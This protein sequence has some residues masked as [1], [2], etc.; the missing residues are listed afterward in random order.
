MREEFVRFK[1][2]DRAQWGRLRD[3]QLEVLSA[4]PWS[5]DAKPS[6]EIVVAS[7]VEWLAP[8]EPSK[9]VCVGLNYR[10]HAA[11]MGEALPE[12]PKLFLKPST[13]LLDPGKSILLPRGS[14]RV[15]YEAELAFVVGTKVGPGLDD[16][17]ALFGFTCANDVTARDLQKKDGQWTRAKGFDTFCP[18]GP[19]LVRG[20]DTADL[21]VECWVNGERKQSSRS[22]QLIFRPEQILN[23]VAEV[24]TLLPGDVI[25]TGTP[26]GIG[27]LKA[28]DEVEVRI[29]GVGSLTNLVINR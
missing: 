6:G 10:D 16:E 28:G 13:A 26:G 11:E 25:L 1:H 4:A 24:M 9:I 3:A 23:F 17:K 5:P 27:P 15:D 7:A 22:S 20:V 18:L 8:A 2:H 19:S 21:A 12:E 29:E 14:D